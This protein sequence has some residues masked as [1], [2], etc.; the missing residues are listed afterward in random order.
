MCLSVTYT[1]GYNSLATAELCVVVE[2]V[3]SLN[4][5]SWYG[6]WFRDFQKMQTGRDVELVIQREHKCIIHVLTLVLQKIQV[7]WDVMLC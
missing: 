5:K 4:I 3:A 7:F 2:V 1:V 6:M